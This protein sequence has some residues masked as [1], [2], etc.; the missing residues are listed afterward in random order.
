MLLRRFF[1]LPALLH[2]LV[3]L[4]LKFLL[5]HMQSSLAICIYLICLISK[6]HLPHWSHWWGYSKNRVVYS[7]RT[8]MS[9]ITNSSSWYPHV[10]TC[11]HTH[12]SQDSGCTVQTFR[13][14]IF[15]PIF[16]MEN[17]FQCHYMFFH[18]LI[19]MSVSCS[20]KPMS[21]IYLTNLLLGDI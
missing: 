15:P 12:F 7:L 8:V 17:I 10:H 1:P 11:T 3:F 18:S 4:I 16:S 20:I 5:F 19:L 2:I 21:F 13:I 6:L 9:A 14:F